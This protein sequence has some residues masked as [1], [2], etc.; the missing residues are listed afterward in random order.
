MIDQLILSKKNRLLRTPFLVKKWFYSLISVLLISSLISW[1][2]HSTTHKP[3]QSFGPCAVELTS[4]SQ[5]EEIRREK[6]A[7]IE[8]KIQ[9]RTSKLSSTNP[10]LVREDSQELTDLKPGIMRLFHHEITIGALN[11]ARN[12]LA[13][14]AELWSKEIRKLLDEERKISAALRA[15]EEA[16]AR[17][18]SRSADAIRD[19]NGICAS[20][21]LNKYKSLVLSYM[22]IAKLTNDF[23][24]LSC[25]QQEG[26]FRETLASRISY[27][28][29]VLLDSLSKKIEPTLSK[30]SSDYSK[31]IT[32]EPNF[33]LLVSELVSL[34]TSFNAQLVT[35]HQVTESKLLNTTSMQTALNE[36]LENV[37]YVN[38][39]GQYEMQ[40]PHIQSVAIYVP[41]I[42]SLIMMP[43]QKVV[44]K[45]YQKQG[46]AA[47]ASVYFHGAGTLRSSIASWGTLMSRLLQN[48]TIPIAIDMPGSL[49]N[50]G[51]SMGSLR[52]TEEIGLYIGHQIEKQ[53][54]KILKDE[55]LPLYFV[56]RSAGATQSFASALFEKIYQH[57]STNLYFL[58][59]FSNPLTDEEQVKNIY[60]KL[61]RGEIDT[62]VKESLNASHELDM[63]MLKVMD[64]I[65]KQNPK[66]FALFGDNIVFPQGQDDED[67]APQSADSKGA[68]GELVVFRDRYAPLA[69]I[70][71]FD[72]PNEKLRKADLLKD[73]SDPRG[74]AHITPDR[75][76]GTHF[77]YSA[78]DNVKPESRGPFSQAIS[79]VDLPKLRD[80]FVE[81]NALKYAML[82]YQIDL[83]PTV[84]VAEKNRQKQLR[85]LATN[86]ADQP[87]GYLRWYVNNVLSQQNVDL[88]GQNFDQIISNTKIRA[89]R[90]DGVP[91]RIKRVYQYWIKE[92]ARVRRLVK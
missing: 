61:A 78:M 11:V 44:D 65:Q 47:F 13:K 85:V 82:D 50:R 92:A 15:K 39:N 23:T 91:G 34:S 71:E 31:G 12:E 17:S 70:Y 66:F 25:K 35:E 38:S 43:N 84:S 86:S 73:Q 18:Q 62:I 19:A 67:G 51:V 4:T 81:L 26:Y 2:A 14:L 53:V 9:L 58:S 21:M 87:D 20:S 49:G 16:L 64:Q 48:G 5:L 68:V 42:G 56:G 63:D 74:K 88:G 24:V 36:Y 29:K 55:N 8:N 57:S 45:I 30:I 54:R 52:T 41:E 37:V 46:K 59:S 72:T 77:L 27:T 10:V 6:I 76:E 80:Q 33:S 22:Q 40:L 7:G 90:E 3:G 79:D 89:G 60:A 28:K 1:P 69:H 83:S 75:L 32:N